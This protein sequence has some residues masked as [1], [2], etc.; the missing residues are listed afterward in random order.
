MFPKLRLKVKPNLVQLQ[1]GLASLPIT[2]AEQR[3]TPLTPVEW[4]ARL[5]EAIT[6]PTCA[7]KVLTHIT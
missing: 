4:K 7:A 5:K 1:G 3:A 2:Q 6:A